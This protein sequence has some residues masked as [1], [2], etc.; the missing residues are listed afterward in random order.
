MPALPVLDWLV[1]LAYFAA[2]AWIAWAV[3]QKSRTTEGYFLGGRSLPGWVVGFSIAGAAISSITFLALP[4]DAFK[5]A[6]LR[7]LPNLVLPLGV[8]AG[9]RYFL[10]FYRDGRTTTAFE[11]LER[12]FGPSTRLYGAFTFLVGQLLRISIILFLLGQLTHE[13]TGLSP[14]ASIIVSGLFVSAYT[15]VGGIAAVVWTDVVQTVILALGGL[16]CLAIVAAQLPGGLFEILAVAWAHDKLS[17]FDLAPGGALQPTRLGLTLSEK[18]VAMMLVVG[19]SHWLGEYACNQNVVQRYCATASTHEARRALWIGCAWM[20]PIWLVFQLLG[21]ALWVF[22]Q[23]FPTPVS[24]GIL[25]GDLT[26]ERIVPH[27]VVTQLPVGFTGLVVAGVLAAAMSTLDSSLNAIAA[28]GVV[29]VYR[30]HVAR[31][32]DDRRD[33]RVAKAIS[34]FAAVAMIA[35]ALL[36]LDA[37]TRTLQDAATTLIALTSGGLLGLYLLGFLTRRGDGRSV[38]F[39]IA[40][41]LALS[42]YRAVSPASWFPAALRIPALDAVHGYYTA[43]LAHVVMFT[44]GWLAG[45]ALPRRASRSTA[46]APSTA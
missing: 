14:T 3:G 38:A 34:C 43:L 35:G 11:F 40:A 23:R 12:R 32:T 13:L 21:T 10:H 39:A 37:R 31:S 16:V 5:T 2:T 42:L 19:A 41:T 18:S 8:L 22:Y 4:A 6:W 46:S 29:D 7:M 17:F 24:T 44:I 28:V 27:F 20:I 25:A 33:L 30:R 45:L 9:S 15:V 1:I 36:L 26:A